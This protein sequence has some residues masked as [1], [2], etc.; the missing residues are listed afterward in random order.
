MLWSAAGLVAAVTVVAVYIL[1]EEPARLRVA[2]AASEEILPLT[3]DCTRA[4]CELAWRA[5]PGHEFRLRV[6]TEDLEVLQ[7]VDLVEA[8][9]FE[10]PS[11]DLA[12]VQ[13]GDGLLWQVTARDPA[14]RTI[15]SITYRQELE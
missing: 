4:R 13:P 2:A 11:E 12:R 7:D 5:L 6:L 8:S 3:K 9:S 14:G 1:R 15:R 10:V